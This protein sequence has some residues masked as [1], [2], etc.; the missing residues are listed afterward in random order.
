MNYGSLS[1]LVCCVVKLLLIYLGMIR[2]DVW[3]D[4]VSF[5]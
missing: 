1:A 5:I 2:T 4:D 3:R